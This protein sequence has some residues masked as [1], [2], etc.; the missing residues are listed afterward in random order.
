MKKALT[1]ITFS[2]LLWGC[3]KDKSSSAGLCYVC[4]SSLQ[5]NPHSA[6]VVVDSSCDFP[7]TADVQYYIQTQEINGWATTCNPY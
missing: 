3:T 7:T 1:I 2:I 5:M 6:N 4:T